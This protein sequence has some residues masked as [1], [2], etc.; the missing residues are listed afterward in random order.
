MDEARRFRLAGPEDLPQI[1]DIHL[2]AYSRRHFTSRL[3]VKVLERYYRLFLADGTQTLLLVE[4]GA[5][6]GETILGFAVFGRGI[7]E[8]IKRFK[9]NNSFAIFAASIRHPVA[10][11]G[12][13]LRQLR[14]RATTAPAFASAD[15]LLLSIAVARPGL[16]AGKALIKEFLACSAR[17][18][19][20]RV[21]LYVNADNLAAIN[22]YVR[23]GFLFKDLRGSQYYMECALNAGASM[24]EMM[25]TAADCS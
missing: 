17:Q 8:K 13:I 6:V 12:K 21:G 23:Q 5:N 1:V 11:T 9:R 7:G 4:I 3:P 14:A 2:R 25:P 16:G 24:A 22:A 18:G 10:A 20:E 15:H 19:A